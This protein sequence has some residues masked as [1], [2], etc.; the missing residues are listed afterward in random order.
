MTELEMGSVFGWAAIGAAASLAGMIW[1]FRRGF[2]G[3]IVNLLVG[4]AGAVFVALLSYFVVPLQAHREDT[5]R[6]LFA[7]G[8]AIAALCLVHVLWT[9]AA[10]SASS[11]TNPWADKGARRS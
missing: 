2:V 8:G 6:L 9:R 4:V 5:T 3:V 1:P 7:A 11:G 10:S